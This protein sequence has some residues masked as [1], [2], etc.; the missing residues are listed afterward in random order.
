[1]FTVI[2]IFIFFFELFQLINNKYFSLIN[3]KG[4][5][6][7]SFKYILRLLAG[8]FGTICTEFSPDNFLD[9]KFKMASLENFRQNMNK[10]NLVQNF[11]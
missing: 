3:H 11:I 7:N 1:M 8:K 6:K 2:L 10:H 9:K 4:V 5:K